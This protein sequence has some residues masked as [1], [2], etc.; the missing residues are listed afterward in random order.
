MLRDNEAANT[1]CTRAGERSTL[2]S[3]F[4][5][6]EVADPEFPLATRLHLVIHELV[7]TLECMLMQ[8]PDPS[9]LP[10]GYR[11]SHENAAWDE[12]SEQVMRILGLSEIHKGKAPGEEAAFERIIDR[13]K[14]RPVNP[15]QTTPG[16]IIHDELRM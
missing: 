13:N 1:F 9:T 4:F 11:Y 15:S 12:I 16:R 10:E 14:Y 6:D 5:L 8:I 7:H 3:I 2:R